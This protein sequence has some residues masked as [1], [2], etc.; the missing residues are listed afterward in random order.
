MASHRFGYLKKEQ[1][2]AQYSWGV[3]YLGKKQ[4]TFGTWSRKFYEPDEA[5]NSQ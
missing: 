5:R 1:V 3:M 4:Q 2:I